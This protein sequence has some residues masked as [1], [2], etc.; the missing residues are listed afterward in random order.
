MTGDDSST[1][2]NCSTPRRHQEENKPLV[3]SRRSKEILG[4]MGRSSSS[5]S[6]SLAGEWHST[7][8]CGSCWYNGTWVISFDS[9]NSDHQ[10]TI[11][12]QSGVCCGCCPNL[13]AKSGSLAHKMDKKGENY[14]EGRLGGKTISLQVITETE[15]RHLT[16]DGMC[17]L[18]RA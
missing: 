18:T 7:H 11:S 13:C 12:E 15:L 8:S 9:R 2:H 6:H 3:H 1:N 16:T 17:T 4:T 5:S 10:I 14:W